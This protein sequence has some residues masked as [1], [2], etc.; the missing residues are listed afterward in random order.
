V[1]IASAGRAPARTAAAC[2][3]A[4]PER[5]SKD[6]MLMFET[7]GNPVVPVRLA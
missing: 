7:P 5:V 3:A 6:D 2:A 1:A 4:R